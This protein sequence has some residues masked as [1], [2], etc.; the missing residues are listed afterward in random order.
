MNIPYRERKYRRFNLTFP[1]RVKARSGGIVSEINGISRN[2]SIGGVLLETESIIPQDSHVSFTVAVRDH[3]IVR[4]TVL[5]GEGKVVRIE[6]ISDAALRS[7]WSAPTQ[8]CTRS[9]FPRCHRKTES[10]LLVLHDKTAIS[11]CFL[12]I[13]MGASGLRFDVLV[14]NK[15]LL[16]LVSQKSQFSSGSN[17]VVEKLVVCVRPASSDR[18]RLFLFPSCQ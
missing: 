10:R 17:L 1:M 18:L 2:L 13:A 15:P 4:P 7:R 14:K 12:A 5:V 6:R 16:W 8:W 9:S 11:F 3:Q